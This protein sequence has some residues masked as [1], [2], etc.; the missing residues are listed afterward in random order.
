MEQ[1]VAEDAKSNTRTECAVFDSSHGKRMLFQSPAAFR[2]G[3]KYNGSARIT[4]E[5]A[6]FSPFRML[7][8][9]AALRN[10]NATYVMLIHSRNRLA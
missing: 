6:A 9:R 4:T 5:P 3:L 8:D 1:K 10:P 2:P 7:R